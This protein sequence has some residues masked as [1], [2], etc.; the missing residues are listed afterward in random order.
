M[1]SMIEK[2]I[3]LAVTGKKPL[4]RLYGAE[5][6]RFTFSPSDWY[7]R[8]F[9]SIILSATHVLQMFKAQFLK[10]CAVRPSIPAMKKSR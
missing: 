10:S 3:E 8:T 1:A 2:V 9:S 4:S 5:L 7:M 6:L